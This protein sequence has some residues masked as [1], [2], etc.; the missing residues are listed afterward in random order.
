MRF[1]HHLITALFISCLPMMLHAQAASSTSALSIGIAP[2]FQIPLAGSESSYSLGG[3]FGV[4]MQYDLSQPSGLLLRAGLDYYYDPFFSINNDALSLFA[5]HA[6]AGYQ[7]AFT[8]RFRLGAFAGG[9]YNYG[10]KNST[11]QT[12]GSLYAEGGIGVDLVLTPAIGLSLGGAWRWYAGLLNAASAW[13]GATYY[14]TGAEARRQQIQSTQPIDVELLKGF[15]TAGPGKGLSILKITIDPVFPVFRKYYDDHPIGTISIKNN[16]TKA[17]TGV[18]ASV[19]IKDYMNDPKSTTVGR[20]E[21]G[22]TVEAP[23]FA[24]FNEHVLDTTEQTKASAEIAVDYQMNDANYRTPATETVRLLDRNAMTWEDD[25]RAAAFVTS[26]DPAV[27]TFAKN[28]WGMVRDLR[29]AGVNDKL[30]GAFA[31]HEALGLYGMAYVIDPASSYAEQSKKTSADFLQF[32]R[33]T[34]QYKAGDC[35]DLSILNA[36]LLEAIGVE[37][38]F[39]TVPGHIFIA[40]S[41]DISPDEARRIFSSVDDLIFKGTETWAPVEIT[42]IQNGFLPAWRDAAKEWRE[43]DPKGLAGFYPIRD[44]WSIYEAVGLPGTSPEIVMPP[45]EKMLPTFQKEVNVFIDGELKPQV[46]R[47]EETLK[48]TKDAPSVRNK[49]GVL[50]ARYGRYEQAMAQLTLA[51]QQKEYLPALINMA[52]VSFLTSKWSDARAYYDRASKLDPLNPKILLGLARAAFELEDYD[53]ATK[54]Y[55]YV[56]KLDPDLAGKFAYLEQGNAD[57]T[58]AANASAAKGVVVWEETQ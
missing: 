55:G 22:A 27:L 14:V 12:G 56:K 40:F 41:L 45:T 7:F 9:G 33:Q 36:A 1:R 47:L 54:Q 3:S 26:K 31:M 49:L 21:P 13:I 38:A 58:R 48:T 11:M 17:I 20:I 35:D 15:R 4:N 46:A 28:I 10:F 44:A 5:L 18:T 29:V 19:N 23:I 37:T 30:M 25:R 34:L 8:P 2:S 53:T 43:N 50:Y 32:P 57:A 51:L 6:D 24:L 39:I 52:N 42:N 16:E